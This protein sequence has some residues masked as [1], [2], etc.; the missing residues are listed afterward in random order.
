MTVALWT[1]NNTLERMMMAKQIITTALRWLLGG[2]VRRIA[3]PVR[4]RLSQGLLLML[5]ALGI[6]STAQAAIIGIIVKD[7]S[8]TV[9][10]SGAGSVVSSPA[11][12]NCGTDCSEG[13]LYQ[14][15][16]P[17][18][19]VTLTATPTLGY[20]FT[21]WS[22][23]CTGTGSCVA[24]MDAYRNVTATFKAVYPLTVTLLTSGPVVG[25][26]VSSP[27][28]IFCGSDFIDCSE[29]YVVDT[30]VTLTATPESGYYFAGWGG[31]CSGT[32]SCVVTMN[33][34]RSVTATFNAAA[35]T[36]T[37]TV[38]NA[39]TGYGNVGSSPGGISCWVPQPNVLYLV[40]P[41]CSENYAIGT[42]V[43][44]TP[45][46]A[47]GSY[48]AGWSGSC[49][50]TG[51]CVVTMNAAR[52][53]TATFKLNPFVATTSSVIT[54]TSATIT[55]RITF[56]T[57]D[58]GKQGSVFV[59]AWVPVN[60]LIALGIFTPLSS[61]LNVIS[62]PLAEADPEA[63]V[64]VQLTSSGWQLVVNGQLIPY[65]SGVLGD[66]LA[67]QTILNNA[68]PSSLIGSQFCLGYGA[69]AAEMIAAGRMLP[70]ATITNQYSISSTAT[71]SCI[72][73]SVIEFYNTNLDHYFITADS[74][75]AALIDGGS[76]GPGWMRTGNTFKSGGGTFVCRFYGSMSPGP[77]S[78]FYTV[79]PDECAYL[80]QLQAS[81]PAT[82][83]RWNFE[84]LDFASTPATNG[85]CL[86][87]TVPVYRAYNNGY[88]RGVDSNHRITS[89]STAIQEV[90]TRGWSNEG[91][92]M[93]APN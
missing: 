20:Y 53:V 37:L 87:G 74:S 57:P 38:T 86:G 81:T 22:G 58:V 3:S 92:V 27:V 91:V 50:G 18:A 15:G 14:L 6:V 28:G 26:V 63:F 45:T 19:S 29:N 44:L 13:Y 48:F 75:E 11:G 78:H 59:T 67:A 77:N 76:A 2:G 9:T 36:A 12:I 24:T 64:L 55:T 54:A 33:V 70:V 8:L 72:I 69:S 88:A 71:G 23:D 17:G 65:A 30:T 49:T 25:R 79:D 31:D 43:T 40:G 61:G 56:N 62:T 60:G 32:G 10:L 47:S 7:V 46:P 35:S 83:K 41:D 90:V 42:T 4:T 1:T 93:C 51:S 21:G 52:N 5:L 39:G 85:A 73:A 16:T 80:K 89:N 84:S 34:A 82:Q 66:L 68:N